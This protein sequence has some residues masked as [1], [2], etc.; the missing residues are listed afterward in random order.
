MFASSK[1]TSLMKL[2]AKQR[3]ASERLRRQEKCRAPLPSA[4]MARVLRDQFAQLICQQCSHFA[5]AARRDRTRFLQ[6][7]GLQCDSDFVFRGHSACAP[8]SR[9]LCHKVDAVVPASGISARS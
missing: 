2:I 1:T 6:Q 3:V 9:K 8:A 7:P 4:L 5:P